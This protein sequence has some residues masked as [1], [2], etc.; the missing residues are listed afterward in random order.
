M[1]G[2]YKLRLDDIQLAGPR[3]SPKS[4]FR[5]PAND[6]FAMVVDL[7]ANAQGKARSFFNVGGLVMYPRGKSGIILCQLRIPEETFDSQNNQWPTIVGFRLF[8]DY[9]SNRQKRE[10]I[11]GMLLA[12]LGLRMEG[13]VVLGY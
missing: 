1:S 7:P 12:N 8:D 5:Q 6:T 2:P 4:P 9:S 10:T 13:P 3:V 11:L